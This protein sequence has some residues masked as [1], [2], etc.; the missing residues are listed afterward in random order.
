MKEKG[1][2]RNEGK[3]RVVCGRSKGLESSEGIWR[4]KGEVGMEG[5]REKEGGREGK[6][7]EGKVLL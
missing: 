5:M 7:D 1:T 4:S 2:E 3:K 6:G